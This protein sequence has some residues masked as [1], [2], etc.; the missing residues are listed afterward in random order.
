M[1]EVILKAPN[2]FDREID[3]TQRVAP[4]GGVPATVIGAASKGPAFVPTTVSNFTE[5]QNKFGVLDP[6]FVGG[7]A[8]QKFFDG[9]GAEVASANYIRV[10]GC[11]ANSSSVDISTTQTSG[12]V[13]NAGMAVNGTTVFV[14]GAVQGVAQFLVANHTVRTNE[15]F[16]FPVFTDNDSFDAST[17]K[18]NLVRAVLFTTPDARFMVLSGSDASSYSHG[19]FAAGTQNYEAAKV[20][21]AGSGRMSNMFKLILS[22]SDGSSF[23]S[24]DGVSGLR[25]FSASLD[26]TADEYI[27][28]LLNTNPENFAAAK[29]LLYM[30]FPVD[31]EV[32]AV[33]TSSTEPTVGILSGSANTNAVGHTFQQA[34]GNFRARYRAPKTTMFISQ[35]FGG[36]EYDLFYVESIDDGV[37]AN[38]KIK[39]SVS[40]IMRST[41]PSTE[42]G[43]FTLLVRSFDDSDA[44]MK[45]LE[46]FS[47]LSLD[48]N[49]DNYIV[50]VIGDKKARFNF[51]ATEASDRSV[52]VTGKYG[53]RSKFIRVIPSAQLDS[54]EVPLRALPFGFRG[55]SMPLT[56]IALTD[57]TSSLGASHYRLAGVSGAL[58]MAGAIVP[59]VP[60]RFTLTRNPLATSGVEGSPGQQSVL[61]ARLFWGAK[62]ER[63]NSNVLNVNVNDEHNKIFENFAKFAGIEQLGVLTT[64]SQSDT[65]NNNKFTLARVAFNT[66]TLNDVTSVPT[67]MKSAAYL[68]N[69]RLDP[70][71]YAATN[72]SSR[73]TFATAINGTASDSP[74][75]WNQMA[76]YAKFTT[77]LQGGWDGVN[78]FDKEAV[79]FSDR[80]TSTELGPDGLHGLAHANYSSPGGVGSVNWTGVGS[81]NSNVA[82]YKA[83]VDIACNPSIANNNIL[84]IPGQ[85]DP[86]V[87]NYALEKN[88]EFG[89]SFL[90]LDIP[91]YDSTGTTSGRIFDGVTNKHVDV[92]TTAATFIN[93]FVDNNAAAAYFPNIVVE[94]AVNRRRVTLPATVAALAALSYN[95]RVKFPWY[96]PAGFNR[97]S[98][99]FVEQTA[100]RIN[101]ADRNTLFD[102][103]INPIF[104]FPGASYVFF[105]QNTLQQASTALES[106]NVKR[107][108]IE[109][110]RQ[111]VAIGNRIIFEQNTPSARAQVVNELTLVCASV[112]LQQGIEDFR[113]IC[114]GRNNTAEDVNGNRLNVQIRVRPTKSIEYVVMDFAI[115]PGGVSA[116]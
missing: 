18:A 11:G 24:D 101:Q 116:L 44:D 62:F 45:V 64:G 74:A 9:K 52:V 75:T 81:A 40:N 28:K 35:P 63:N 88:L 115:L 55:P 8:I 57:S 109:L 15:T 104:K 113:I 100:V 105:S 5:F 98:L 85:R 29:H 97:G 107:M 108:L 82:A 96:S 92:S 71:T 32:A 3:L 34:F 73:V 83:G 1:P 78:I 69:A 65:L 26:P 7:Y 31:A 89:L 17:D 33:T 43:S 58:T 14:S 13:Q 41:N 68:R 76:P 48:P 53:N 77:F 59:P 112:Q 90:V 111:I 56:N 94:D 61:D 54:G 70:V 46:T 2:Y 39:V 50:K 99:D 23:A 27:G 106:I 60:Y 30:H 110:K 4:V 72:Y 87:T 37:W 86:L 36:M 80:S 103:N 12:V 47:N 79:K 66:T 6:R 51:D 84:A 102:A 91:V 95:D 20:G 25:I 38:D 49:S 10:L 16:G 67:A 93:R 22:S 42:V 114:D 21:G 19:S